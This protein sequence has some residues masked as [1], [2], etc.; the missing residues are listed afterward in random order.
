MKF[1]ILGSQVAS[2]ANFRGPLIR[3][4]VAEGHEVVAVAPDPAEPWLSRLREAGARYIE[5]PMARTGINPVQDIKL[6]W[7][8]YRM[9]RREKPDILFAFHAKPV[10]FGCLAAWLAGV[11]RRTAMIEGLGQGFATEAASFKLRLVRGILPFLYKVGLSC[12][13]L[14]F[15]LNPDDEAEF[16][17]RGI[18]KKQ[19]VM[20]LPGIGVDLA[21]FA[22]QPMPPLAV[23]TFLMVA[24]LLVDKGV[25]DFAAA[26]AIVKLRH[27]HVKFI[28]LGPY[29]PSPA[30]IG[31]D[32]VRSWSAV[33]YLGETSDVRPYLAACHVF[34][35]PTFYREGLP[36]SILEAMA[37]G[38]PVLTTHAPGARETVVA[39]VNGYLVES[40]NPQA[41]AA[42][43]EQLLAAPDRLEPMGRASRELAEQRYEVGAINRQIIAALTDGS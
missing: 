20:Q 29:D 42:A 25:K 10:I 6:T 41:L 22:P 39:G 17:E 13:H 30:G 15:F 2:L 8:L 12:A 33:E 28:L 23:P 26:A 27:P 16:R 19:R 11:P 31:P 4:L 18:V 38:R 9:F 14:V 3:E 43:M 24:R 7:W 21:H 32:E 37:T 34:V 35:L 36:R 5:S 1:L 40:R